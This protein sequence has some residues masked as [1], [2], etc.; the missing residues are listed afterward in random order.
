ML[1]VYKIKLDLFKT[2]HD[3]VYNFE[4]LKN[5]QSTYI[6][7]LDLQ[8]SGFQ[9]IQKVPSVFIWPVR[10]RDHREM[11]FWPGPT[12]QKNTFGDRSKNSAS[13]R[14]RCRLP[15][16]KNIIRKG[17]NVFLIYKRSVCLIS[18]LPKTIW[19]YDFLKI[20]IVVNG[21]GAAA[22]SCL[23]LYIRLGVK[24]KNIVLCDSQGVIRKNRDFLNICP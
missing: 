4:T 1:D 14:L 7:P 23:K 16:F 6:I 9:K 17:Q 20:K 2:D 22:I 13:G 11:P 18:P 5:K 21:A 8:F 15:D 24:R 10:G 19:T 12:R 3:C